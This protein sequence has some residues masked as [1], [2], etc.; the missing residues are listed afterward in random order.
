[1]VNQPSPTYNVLKIVDFDLKALF[2]SYLYK[3]H[4]T[5]LL[6]HKDASVLEKFS[7]VLESKQIK[8]ISLFFFFFLAF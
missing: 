4:N 8:T 5:Q 6:E 7:I 2:S 3:D 1:V